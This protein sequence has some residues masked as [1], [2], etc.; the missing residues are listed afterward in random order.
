MEEKPDYLEH[1]KRLRERFERAGGKGLHDYEL[2]ELLLTYAVP[3][4]DVKPVA[5]ALIKRFGGVSGVMDAGLDDLQSV[6][7]LGP[8]S[9]ILIRAVK[10]LFDAYLAEGAR[11]RSALSSPDAVREFA[12]MKLAGL[13]HEAF[14]V[15]Y[16]NVKNR[17]LDHEIINE[18]TVDRAIVYPR[19]I[20][21]HALA[22][23]AA[24]LILVHNH[25]SGDPSPSAEDTQLTRSIIE[26]ARTMDIKVLDH[27]VVGKSGHFSFHENRLLA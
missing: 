7:G 3:R 2:I 8:T 6:K 22:H 5:K 24:G 21:E 18:G 16:L 27:I 9:A 25:P 10:E 14:M 4:V 17:V 12:K 23:H 19:R 26:A 13:P 1:R 15:I 20:V 11:E